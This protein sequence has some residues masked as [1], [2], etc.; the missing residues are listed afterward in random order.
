MKK[1]IFLFLLLSSL[2]F[3]LKIT[4]IDPIN[5][6]VVVE[7]DKGT[8]VKGINIAIQGS[9][10]KVVEII[11]PEEY[12]LDGNTMVITVEK[13]TIILDDKGLGIFSLDIDLK[14]TNITS[15]QTLVDKLDVK[16]K[17]LDK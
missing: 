12:D 3:S 10:G 6:G 5:F 4:S 9:K 7:G 17:Y 8:A 15:Y 1:I 11:I 2:T 14:L 16:V 13:K